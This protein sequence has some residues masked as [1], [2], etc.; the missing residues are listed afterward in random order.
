MSPR[1]SS[2]PCNHSWNV[3]FF[4][5]PTLSNSYLAALSTIALF[6]FLGGVSFR[7]Y[8]HRE[9]VNNSSHHSLVS[10]AVSVAVAQGI[11]VAASESVVGAAEVVAGAA[12]VVAGQGSA[13]VAAAAA[14]VQLGD[15][16]MDP[17]QQLPDVGVDAR[18]AVLTAADAPGQADK[19]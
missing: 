4:I 17:G 5:T 7:R 9:N 3:L 19:G 15:V 18:D 14:A 13:P 1:A 2:S 8:S 16:F 12:V 11:V 6:L 10:V